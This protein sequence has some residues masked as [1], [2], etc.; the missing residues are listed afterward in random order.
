MRNLDFQQGAEALEGLVVLGASSAVGVAGAE[1]ARRSGA[2]IPKTVLTGLGSVV[3]TWVM[4]NA[5]LDVS[6]TP[7]DFAGKDLAY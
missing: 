7:S 5:L 4:A 3:L 6:H 2:N 1:M